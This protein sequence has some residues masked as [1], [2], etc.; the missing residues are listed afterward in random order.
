MNS[1]DND[2]ITEQNNQDITQTDS[3]ISDSSSENASNYSVSSPSQA[4]ETQNRTSK[5]KRADFRNKPLELRVHGNEVK[6]KEGEPLDHA[7]GRFKRQCQQAGVFAEVRKR[8]EF[9]KPSVRR[10]KKS[11]EAR[12]RK[13]KY[14]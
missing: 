10:K 9:M 7:L 11:E 3:A 12:K 8:R 6:L 14:R 2:K 13:Y 1:T 5:G 4:E